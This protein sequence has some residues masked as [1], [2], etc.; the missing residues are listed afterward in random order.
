M[1]GKLE[2]KGFGQFVIFQLY[3]QPG[4]VNQSSCRRVS[5]PDLRGPFAWHRIL[6]CAAYTNSSCLIS[7]DAL[8]LRPRATGRLARSDRLPSCSAGETC[9]FQRLIQR[10]GAVAFP[11][12]SA[13][14]RGRTLLYGFPLSCRAPCSFHQKSSVTSR[15]G[16]S[17]PP[18]CSLRL[19][20]TPRHG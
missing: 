5:R 20:V 12:P 16:L 1:E 3:T 10:Q 18:S 4:K 8:A 6:Q 19:P 15:A 11:A 7:S 14:C 2:R 13:D 17:S 9:T